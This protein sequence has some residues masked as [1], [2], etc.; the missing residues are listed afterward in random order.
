[1]SVPC[2]F[3]NKIHLA[4]RVYVG[5]YVKGDEKLGHLTVRQYPYCE[6]LFTKSQENMKRHIKVCAA[7]EGITDYFDNGDIFVFQDNLKY[8]GNAS[9]IVYFY[10]ET[11]TGNT[12]FFYPKMFVL[13]YCQIYSFHPRLNLEKIVIFRSF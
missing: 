6:N 12:V 5:K 9:F 11:I 2:Y 3:T 8:L 13:R 10:F 4:Y 1:M 7:K